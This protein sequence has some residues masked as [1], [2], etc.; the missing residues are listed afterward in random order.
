MI[1]KIGAVI[2]DLDG[3]L[4]NTIPLCIEAF[5]KSI[6]PL[7][8]RKL[9]ED[10]ITATFGVSE[11]GTVKALAPENFDKGISNYLAFYEKLHEGC[12][13]PFDG[14]VSLL[15]GLKNKQIRVSMVTGKGIES[16]K[17]TLEKFG[18]TDYFDI[19]EAGSPDGSRKVEGLE[20]VLNY[21]HDLSKG[22]VIYVGDSVNDILAC[23]KVGIPIVAAAWAETAQPMKLL[24]Q[25][26]D[27][28]FYSVS[29][30]C[31]WINS[32]IKF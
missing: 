15:N 21:Y 30:F 18:I 9:S 2:F 31:N 17:I 7:V 6:E 1:D 28:L 10:E 8:G 23:K 14:I 27:K 16:T 11:E 24:A 3:T 29:E 25:R 26:P 5:K 32:V 12:S 22:E 4:G 13:Q 19:I 20:A